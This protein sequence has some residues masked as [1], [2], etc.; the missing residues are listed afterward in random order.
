MLLA[1]REH[2]R[3]VHGQRGGADAALGAEER[4]DLAELAL[5]TADAAAAPAP[6][7]PWR[8]GTRCA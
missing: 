6:G 7:A 3:E 8:R 5:A 2:R 1:L 4:I